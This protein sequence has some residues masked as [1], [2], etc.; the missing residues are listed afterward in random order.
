MARVTNRR[1]PLPR[2]PQA[3]S[4]VIPSTKQNREEFFRFSQTELLGVSNHPELEH[5]SLLAWGLSESDE[6]PVLASDRN[7]TIDVL[8]GC[9]HDLSKFDQTRV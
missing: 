4:A 6:D 1:S 5:Q 3:G 7:A 2:P 9:E 8:F